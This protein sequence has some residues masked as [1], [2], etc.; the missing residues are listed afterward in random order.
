MAEFSY[1]DLISDETLGASPVFLSGESST[2]MI[3]PHVDLVI[4]S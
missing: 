1:D 2:L 3:S 4:G